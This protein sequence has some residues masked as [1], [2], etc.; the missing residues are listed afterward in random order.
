MRRRERLEREEIELKKKKLKEKEEIIRLLKEKEAEVERL[1]REEE[2]AYA[3]REA[4]REAKLNRELTNQ[5]LAEAD[6]LLEETAA[7][8][9][10]R[11]METTEVNRCFEFGTHMYFQPISDDFKRVIKEER[12]DKNLGD[13]ILENK[14]LQSS[15]NDNEETFP[16]LED[17]IDS[18]EVIEEVLES[19]PSKPEESKTTS[20]L[21]SERRVAELNAKVEKQ[22]NKLKNEKID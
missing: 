2:M 3:A 1:S 12:R 7:F 22:E 13:N 8:Q 5:M 11:K 19:F 17:E 6:K 18:I 9:R 4:A 21:E 10:A 16:D 20:Q 14:E 15:S